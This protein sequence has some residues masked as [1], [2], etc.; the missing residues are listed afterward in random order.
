MKSQAGPGLFLLNSHARPRSIPSAAPF[1]A[2]TSTIMRSFLKDHW[3]AIVAIILLVVLALFTVNPG[4]ATPAPSL[5]ARLRTHVAAVAP[6]MD[7]GLGQQQQRQAARY[8]EA[9]LRDEGYAV[10]RPPNQAGGQAP[11]NIEVSVANLAPH[12]KPER[13]FIV[14]A[15]VGAPADGIS[16]DASRAD[17]GA[18]TGTAAVLELARLLKGLRPSLGTEIRFVFFFDASPDPGAPDRGPEPM[19]GRDFIAFVGTLEASRPVQ[20]A[21]AA[22]QGSPVAAIHGLATPAYVQGVTL[23]GHA[24]Y[25]GPG[26]PTVMVTDTA[27]GRYPYFEAAGAPDT[28][29]PADNAPDKADFSGIARV[30]SGLARTIA[31]LAAAQQG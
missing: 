11:R 25:R 10:R 26:A 31:A 3:K 19:S 28:N 6:G 5:A 30:V 4:G 15:H 27:F 12:A 20:R 17:N 8:I 16:L 29:E 13:I 21:L 18:G 9:T 1:C 7:G 23:S 2:R 14:G 24:A 22:F